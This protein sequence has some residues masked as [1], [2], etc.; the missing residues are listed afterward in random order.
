MKE[1]VL[2]GMLLLLMAVTSVLAMAQEE[3][4]EFKEH[5]DCEVDGV[6]YNL[7]EEK[8]TAT[9]TFHD[10]YNFM[11]CDF[12][13]DAIEGVDYNVVYKGDVVIP[14]SIDYEGKQ[15]TVTDIGL[16]AFSCSYDMKSLTL[17]HTLTGIAGNAF[18]FPDIETSL[19]LT[20]YAETSPLCEEW[21]FDDVD[22]T[23]SVLRVPKG[24][25]ELYRAA[26]GWSTFA[27]II[28]IDG[29]GIDAVAG[30]ADNAQKVYDIEGRRL[31]APHK[32]LNIV[33]G[34]KV[35]VK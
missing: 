4:Y 26:D 31:W 18:D 5:Y 32:G 14:G 11:D 1:K 15:Y 30:R 29:T 24:S 23:N 33:D 13:E 22:R 10:T 16:F 17:P 12:P 35:M 7:N 27:N 6:W 9:V 8:M 19:V 34:R 20:C 28:A 3:Y 25:V 2:K 21:A